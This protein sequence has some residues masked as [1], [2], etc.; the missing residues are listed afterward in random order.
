MGSKKALFICKG[1][2]LRSQMAAAIYNKLMGT[3]DA[4]SVGTYPGAPD[5][6]EGQLLSDL[7][8]DPYFFEI[9]EEHG[10]NVRSCRTKRLLPPMLDEYE[11]VVS[12]A[13]DPYVPDFL[14][15]S[16]KVIFW[17]IENPIDGDKKTLEGI[18]GRIERLVGELI[19]KSM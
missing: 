8:E 7:F 2:W 9:M 19:S 3:C 11:I 1:N 15:A 12:M 5:E 13:E 10:M 6:P 14:K 16:E 17:Q 4:D 18:Y